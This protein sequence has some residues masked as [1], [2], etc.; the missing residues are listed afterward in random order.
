MPQQPFVFKVGLTPMG[1]HFVELYEGLVKVG[2][3][4]KTYS[5]ADA[6]LDEVRQALE[7]SAE[8]L[9]DVMQ[10]TSAKGG[11]AQ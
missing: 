10:T 11:Q 9:A 7:H 8:A 6:A 4:R 2:V 1:R 5:S 3:S